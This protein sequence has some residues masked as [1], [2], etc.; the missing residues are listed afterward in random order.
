MNKSLQTPDETESLLPHSASLS[1]TCEEDESPNYQETGPDSDC[2]SN[3]AKLEDAYASQEA[4]KRESLKRFR[5]LLYESAF[6]F[7]F[8][9]ALAKLEEACASQE[10]P[11][12]EFLKRFRQLLY[13]SDFEFG[14]NTAA[15]IYVKEA[16][17]KYPAFS[18]EWINSLYMD[19]FAD[20]PFI[21]C[22]ILRVIGHFEYS[23]MCPQ[24]LTM[25][26]AATNHKDI[27]VCECAVRCFENWEDPE[28]A[29]ILRA[30]DFRHDWLK[31]YVEKVIIFLEGCGS[32]VPIGKKN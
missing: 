12:R 19:N 4:P 3:L 5:Q 6:E 10:A 15:D 17:E 32:H 23:Q 2:L 30:I 26:A 28:G 29:K 31:D 25:A 21:I 20:N 22:A 24:G 7:D 1:Y 9:T 13:E 14:F 8:N 18:R 11:K 27:A 16:L